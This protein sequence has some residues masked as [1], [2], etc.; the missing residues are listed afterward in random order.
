MM[1]SDFLRSVANR[2]DELERENILLRRAIVTCTIKL[3]KEL[4]FETEEDLSEID[5]SRIV[6]GYGSKIKITNGLKKRGLVTFDEIKSVYP[7]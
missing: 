4:P 5:I 2:L 7:K 6:F 3:K 1:D